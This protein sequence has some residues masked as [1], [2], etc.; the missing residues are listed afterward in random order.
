MIK[1]ISNNYQYLANIDR[2]NQRKMIKICHKDTLSQ[3]R[4]LPHM[5]NPSM[6]QLSEITTCCVH[7]Q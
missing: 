3:E 2:I 7:K 5:I 1:F 4:N 6:Q